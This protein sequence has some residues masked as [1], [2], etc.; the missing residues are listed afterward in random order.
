MGNVWHVFDFDSDNQQLIPVNEFSSESDAS[1][2][3][4]EIASFGAERII[5]PDKEISDNTENGTENNKEN[6]VENIAESNVENRESVEDDSEEI[7]EVRP[8][9]IE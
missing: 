2:V 6:N 5:S 8:V 4:A 1:M 3:G 7:S 9:V